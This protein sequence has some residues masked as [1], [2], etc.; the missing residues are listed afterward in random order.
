M[1][2]EAIQVRSPWKDKI[3]GSNPFQL[4]L[5]KQSEVLRDITDQ[6]APLAKNFS[7]YYFWEQ[8]KTSTATGKIYIVDEHSAAPTQDNVGRSGIMATHSGMV[9][10]SRPED[11]GYRVI[12][13][14]I[15]RFIKAA[16][17]SIRLRWRNDEKL[18]AEERRA[19]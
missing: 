6:F 8:T 7:I 16:P 13:A 1:S 18:L 3:T 14:T 4:S 9:K 12:L 5:Q 17:D 11:A 19:E 10:F 2:K 15:C